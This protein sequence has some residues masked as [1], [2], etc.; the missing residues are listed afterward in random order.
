MSGTDDDSQDL[1]RS[2]IPLEAAI[3]M[4]IGH[5]QDTLAPA[6]N[7][8]KALQLQANA[9][10]TTRAKLDHL[11]GMQGLIWHEMQGLREHAEWIVASIKANK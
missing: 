3:A 5:I 7:Y 8:V 6:S 11:V 10:V 4:L 1:D 2:D 9:S